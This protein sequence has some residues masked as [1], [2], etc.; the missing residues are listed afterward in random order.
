MI[1]YIPL[2]KVNMP[3]LTANIF[4]MLSLSSL[5]VLPLDGLFEAI[6]IDD[7]TGSYT[8]NFNNQEYGSQM[9]FMNSP[10][11]YI[12]GTIICLMMGFFVAVDM[13]IRTRPSGRKV[14]TRI[15]NYVSNKATGLRYGVIILFLK[16]GFLPLL[17]FT[18]VNLMGADLFP[19]KDTYVLINF[20]LS[21][22]T[23]FILVSF[24]FFVIWIIFFNQR[25]FET[26]PFHTEFGEI[27]KEMKPRLAC[28]CHFILFLTIRAVY[29]FDLLFLQ[30]YPVSQCFIMITVQAIMVQFLVIQMPFEE[31]TQN[32]LEIFNEAIVWMA[33]CLNL[34]FT[35]WVQGVEIK[36]AVGYVMIALIGLTVIVNMAFVVVEGVRNVIILV[37]K[38]RA[39]IKE[40]CKKKPK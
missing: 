13:L 3:S 26:E 18:G 34:V 40:K 35:Q 4:I 39:W 16:E 37:K 14:P 12:F 32:Y 11:I 19:P 7:Q 2:M 25:W 1:L 22:A 31:K 8:E 10:D 21:I 23:L 29:C 15:K 36:V 9:T 5:N 17:L 20:I 38:T 28:H 27:Y 24:Y 6:G 33:F 30:D